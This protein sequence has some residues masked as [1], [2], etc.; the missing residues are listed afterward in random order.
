MTG[1]DR[2]FGGATLLIRFDNYRVPKDDGVIYPQ[3]LRANV[4]FTPYLLNEMTDSR[5][6]LAST[7]QTFLETVGVTSAERYE[8][9]LAL[10]RY[11]FSSD[12][13]VETQVLDWDNLPL[14]PDPVGVGHARYRLV[15]HT[16]RKKAGC[17]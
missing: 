1:W 6:Y 7:V 10:H 14:L 3:N 13:V 2:V 12:P 17:R 4:Y 15:F 8:R 16:A 5:Q 11:N 9:V